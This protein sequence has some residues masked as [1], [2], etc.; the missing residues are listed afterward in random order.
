[1]ID[2]PEKTRAPRIREGTLDE[3]LH[4]LTQVGELAQGRPL[5]SY[6]ERLAAE[7]LVLVAECGDQLAGFKIAYALDES[8]LYSW[9]GGISPAF[10]RQGLGQSL[11]QTQENWARQHG[12]RTIEVKSSNRFPQ[13]LA[14]LRRNGYIFVEDVE[15]KQLYR[16]VLMVS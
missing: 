11:L 7:H 15:G 3:A 4:I 2:G 6:V 12:Y 8:T 14:M 5:S 1:M 16:K 9:I 10:R 13:M